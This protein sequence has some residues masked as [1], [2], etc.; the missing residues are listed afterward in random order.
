MGDRDKAK[1][2]DAQGAPGDGPNDR[3]ESQDLLTFESV[4]R[5]LR[6]ALESCTKSKSGFSSHEIRKELEALTNLRAPQ[7]DH[8]HP[9]CQNLL[10][11][12]FDR[13]RK[14]AIVNLAGW[15]TL[16]YLEIKDQ[17]TE[18]FKLNPEDARLVASRSISRSKTN[19]RRGSFRGSSYNQ[20]VPQVILIPIPPPQ[21]ELRGQPQQSASPVPFY[22]GGQYY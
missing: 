12:A 22:G 8:T 4:E 17:M 2:A 14:T 5:A 13:A 18:I 3:H 1:G 11:M 21:F 6:S 15:D 7:P 9:N 16:C 19:K 10:V 20:R